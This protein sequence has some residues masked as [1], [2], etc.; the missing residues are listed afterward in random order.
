MHVVVIPLGTI[1]D[2]VRKLPFAEL[3]GRLKDKLIRLKVKGKW[4]DPANKLVIK[5][6]LTDVKEATVGFIRDVVDSGG[7]ITEIMRK[8][9][10]EM[11]DNK[12]HQK[13]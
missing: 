2:I 11:F 1:E 6:P 10:K 13:Q 12:N 5:E 3:F 9:F 8:P 4:S 7:Q